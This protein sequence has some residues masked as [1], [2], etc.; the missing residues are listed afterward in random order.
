MWRNFRRDS[1]H[2]PWH[3]K[4][5]CLRLAAPC[6]GQN[7]FFR[8]LPLQCSP[9]LTALRVKSAGQVLEWLVPW[10]RDGASALADDRVRV[11]DAAGPSRACGIARTRSFPS[12]AP[13][14]PSPQPPLS[15]ETEL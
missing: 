7:L 12:V 6:V 14:H 1:C 15:R 10:C 9:L 13:S 3:G 8:S 5:P 2:S 4:G 11:G